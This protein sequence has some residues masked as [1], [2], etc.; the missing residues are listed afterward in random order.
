MSITNNVVPFDADNFANELVVN[1][2][3]EKGNVFVETTAEYVDTYP[4]LYKNDNDGF[5]QYRCVI[6]GRNVEIRIP[7]DTIETLAHEYQFRNNNAA[8]AE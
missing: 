3:D 1:V 5:I 7:F 2:F 4:N 8:D 6:D